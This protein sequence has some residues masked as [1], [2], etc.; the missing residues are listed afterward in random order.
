MSPITRA[1]IAAA[2]TLLVGGMLNVL[3][4]RLRWLPRFLWLAAV[5][6]PLGV[7]LLVYWTA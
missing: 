6:A 4:V 2:V 1:L 3:A 7:G 5:I